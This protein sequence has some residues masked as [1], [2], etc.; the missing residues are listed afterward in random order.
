[1]ILDLTHLVHL[2]CFRFADQLM[3]EIQ[4]H[5]EGVDPTP[6]LRN[7]VSSKV[8]RIKNFLAHMS[9]GQTNLASFVFL[10]NRAKIR[11]WLSFLRQCQ[12]SEPTIHHYLKNV[13]QFLQYIK[14]TPP[15]TCRLS[16]VALIGIRRELQNLM[17]PVRRSVAVHEV[18]VKQAKEGRLIP[19]ATLRACREAAKKKIPE[20]LGKF[21]TPLL[22]L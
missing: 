8:F 21:L 16:R 9:A 5:W 17:R 2:V 15:P 10:D 4:G 20:I 11:S 19:K 14:E 18:A 22:R 3:E 6:K 13:L 12:I 7:N 1:M